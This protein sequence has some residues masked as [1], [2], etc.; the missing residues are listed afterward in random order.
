MIGDTRAYAE[1]V[2]IRLSLGGEMPVKTLA[3]T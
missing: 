1:M 2:N 3:N